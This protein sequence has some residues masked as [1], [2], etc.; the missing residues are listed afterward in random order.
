MGKLAETMR[1]MPGFYGFEGASRGAV[2]SAEG[3]LGVVFSDDYREYL[4]CV[5]VCS[6]NGHEIAGI[7][8]STRLDVVSMTEEERRSVS[9]AHT[10]WYAIERLGIDGAVA[11]QNA[12]GEVFVSLPSCCDFKKVAE[13]LLEYLK[14]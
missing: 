5:G 7:G 8:P 13:S 14:S 11:W 4:E 1:G 2:S 9:C 6:V 12:A 3:A 10:D